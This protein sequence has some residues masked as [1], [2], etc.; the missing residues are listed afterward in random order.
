MTVLAQAPPADTLPSVAPEDASRSTEP[1][2]VVAVVMDFVGASLPQFDRLLNSLRLSPAGPGLAGSLFQWSRG[3]PDGVR[4]TEVWQSLD[5]FE[6]F[7]RDAIEPRRLAVGLPEPEIT[8]Y[9]VHSYL[10]QGPPLSKQA[11]G[12]DADRIAER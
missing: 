9:Q 1:D 12:T 8:T 5:Q 3:T 11:D 7:L 2:A 10:T 4:V 6:L